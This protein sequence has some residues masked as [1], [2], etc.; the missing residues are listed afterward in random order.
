MLELKR[1]VCYGKERNSKGNSGAVDEA[2]FELVHVTSQGVE[3]MT[4]GQVLFYDDDHIIR[5]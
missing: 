2:L 1:S 4:E 5:A 3:L